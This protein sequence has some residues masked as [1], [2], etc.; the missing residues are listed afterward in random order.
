MTLPDRDQV[1]DALHLIQRHL[2]SE[3]IV[4]SC[5]DERVFGCISCTMTRLHEDLDMLMYEIESRQ[6]NRTP[7]HDPS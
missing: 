4:D 2:R 1:I 5:R 3:Y 7:P 6:L